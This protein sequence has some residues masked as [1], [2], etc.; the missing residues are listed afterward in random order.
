MAKLAALV[1][2]L[3]AAVALAAPTDELK[4]FRQFG[5]TFT[6]PS[7]WFLTAQ[8]ISHAG[9]PVYR[10]TVASRSV[11]RTRADTGP[12][13]PGIARQLRPDS[14]LAFLREALGADRRRSLPRMARRPKSF[15]L[16]TKADRSLCGFPNGGSRWIPFRDAGRAFYL[17]IY[18]GPKASGTARSR[19]QRLLD[20]MIISE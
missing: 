13:L 9:N 20:D 16:P 19:L 10:F 2:L 5:I 18:V 6:Y 3:W 15:A 12:C 11:R 17:G 14:V 1:C 8:P 7:H 4:R